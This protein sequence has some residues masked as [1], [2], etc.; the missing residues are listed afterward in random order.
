MRL[1]KSPDAARA[2]EEARKRN[3]LSILTPAQ[4]VRLELAK[5]MIL[6]DNMPLHWIAS[7]LNCESADALVS[8]I[9]CRDAD[10]PAKLG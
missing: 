9:L 10:V 4:C 2:I 3:A 6:K 7:K 8:V 5:A 1:P